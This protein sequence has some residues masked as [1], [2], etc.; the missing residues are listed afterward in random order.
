MTKVYQLISG[1]VVRAIFLAPA[2]VASHLLVLYLKFVWGGYGQLV[3]NILTYA[4]EP[5]HPAVVAFA[6]K[7]IPVLSTFARNTP[8]T[9]DHAEKLVYGFF[10]SVFLGLFVTF[11]DLM[12]TLLSMLGGGRKKK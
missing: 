11:V 1:L 5:L 10:L 7:Y 3:D 2:F 9:Q 12:V 6:D 4:L 8:F